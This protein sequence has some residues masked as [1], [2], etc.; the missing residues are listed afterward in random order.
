MYIR[1]IFSHSKINRHWRS[2]DSLS[3]EKNRQRS[4]SFAMIDIVNHVSDELCC[5]YS[6]LFAIYSQ[7]FNHYHSQYFIESWSQKGGDCSVAR[8]RVIGY[9]YNI[10]SL[11]QKSSYSL[12]ILYIFFNNY[13]TRYNRATKLM[14]IIILL[15]F[16]RFI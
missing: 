10:T 5:L 16:I 13:I 2:S 3:S 14:K 8:L 12:S 9:I 11:T 7:I 4:C 1:H 6:L 15:Y